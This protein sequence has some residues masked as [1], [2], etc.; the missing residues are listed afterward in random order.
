MNSITQKQKV[1][2]ALWAIIKAIGLL[3][4]D[5]TLAKKNA[6]NNS[7]RLKEYGSRK[8][9]LPFNCKKGFQALGFIVS[10]KVAALRS[11]SQGHGWK[12]QISIATSPQKKLA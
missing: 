2:F 5:T 7:S 8:I 12:K 1:I 10:F 4:S 9:N 3:W 6:S 11:H